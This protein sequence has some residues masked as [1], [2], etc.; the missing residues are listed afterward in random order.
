MIVNDVDRDSRVVFVTGASR[1]IGAAVALALA[2]RGICPVLA[3]REPESA[4]AA[5]EAVSAL[6]V[7]PLVVRCDVADYASVKAAVDATLQR[8]G[9]LDAVVNNA[10]QLAP[11]GR[12][13]DTDPVEWA[14]AVAVN[15]TGCYHVVHAALPSL[16]AAAG[17]VVNVSTGAAHT[18]R[19]GWSAYCSSKAGLVMMT[20][21]L[22]HEYAAQGLRAYGL[23]PGL[24]DTRMQGLIRASGMNE[25]SRVPREKLAPP[26]LSAGVVAWLAAERPA[27]L[28]GQDL[29]VFD[30]PFMARAAA[31]AR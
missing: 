30:E 12:L 21:S 7:A 13:G 31:G 18:P 4:R 8:W 16:L 5:A 6:G 27:D 26:E 20:R 28:A 17:T 2:R 3:V 19:E 24:V 15:L 9:R 10:G 14:S 25:I 23:Q 11:I 22:H 29:S 1:G